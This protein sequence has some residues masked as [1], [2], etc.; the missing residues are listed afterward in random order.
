MSTR[1]QIIN[2]N[3]VQSQFASLVRDKENLQKQSTNANNER[4][5]EE[6]KLL[7]YRSIQS[8]LSEKIR[9]A[10]TT[11]GVKSKKKQMLNAESQRLR[12]VLQDD[13]DAIEKLAV[14]VE[15]VESENIVKKFQF[16]KEMDG[17]NDDLADALRMYEEKGIEKTLKNISSCRFI[18]QFLRDKLQQPDLEQNQYWNEVLLSISNV[19]DR[20]EKNLQNLN[21]EKARCSSLRAKAEELRL[22]VEAKYSKSLGRVELDEL[23]SLWEQNNEGSTNA[24]TSNTPD[25]I[26]QHPVNMHLFYGHDLGGNT[27]NDDLSACTNSNEKEGRRV[28]NN[29]IHHGSTQVN[30]S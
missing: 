10:H 8:T 1:D 19:I 21:N 16:V 28:S 18:E 11:L 13:R 26:Q 23:E 14:K 12:K 29:D 9:I 4:R 25:P 15:K 6:S 27:M 20:F 24:S 2:P 7:H 22:E 3:S 17:L 30:C 5:H